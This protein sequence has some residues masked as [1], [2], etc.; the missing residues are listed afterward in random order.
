MDEEDLAELYHQSGNVRDGE[1]APDD[2][3]AG[4]NRDM[5]E[6]DAFDDMDLEDLLKESRTMLLKSL[7]RA[8]KGGFATPAQENTLRQLLKDN[9]M[10]MGTLSDPNEGGA[11]A[12]KQ[13]APLP[14]FEDP[15]Y[16]RR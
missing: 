6:E 15:D 13:K 11:G 4:H 3:K 2:P 5:E 8:V 1:V 16:S 14:S 10:V 12:S 9:G 7:M